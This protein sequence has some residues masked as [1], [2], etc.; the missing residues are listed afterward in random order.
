M[1]IRDL[2]IYTESLDTKIKHYRDNAELECVAIMHM[3]DVKGQQL[4]L[5]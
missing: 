5:N 3:S 1:A 2:S 4:K